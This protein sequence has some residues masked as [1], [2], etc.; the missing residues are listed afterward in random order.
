MK[1]LV[2]GGGGREHALAWKLA[3]SPQAEK[4]YVA[5]GNAGTALAL[6]L[7][8][9]NIAA[10]DTEGLL[11][12]A[13]AAAIDLTVVGPE[14]PLAAGIVDDFQK[15]NLAIFGPNKAC[16]QLEASKAFSKAFM[17]AHRIPTASYR[18]FTD[19]NQ[20]IAYI[21]Q[22]GTPLVIKVDGLAAGK[23]VV[24]AQTETQ[25]IDAIRNILVANKFGKAGTS[26]IIEE[27]LEGEELSF[28]AMVDG[29]TILPLATSQD[30]KARD[31]GNKGP[32]T[33]GMG[34][35]SPASMVTPEI[36]TVIMQQVMRPVVDGMAKAGTPY[37]GFLYA[38][39]ML[40]QEGPK[41]LEFNCRLGDPEAQPIMMRLQGD[42][43][44]LCRLGS[45][46][47]L[48]KGTIKWDPRPAVGVVMA[49]RHYPKTYAKGD[50]IKGLEHSLDHTKVFHAGTALKSSKVVT[51]SGRV[52]CVTA[53][54]DTL[55]QAQERA[56]HLTQ[57]IHW[58]HEF[59]RTDIGHKRSVETVVK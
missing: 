59:Y 51:D 37:V 56:Y 35:Y 52:L 36:E 40:T 49:S 5:P 46:G 21:Q 45:H 28:I 2:I 47:Q 18:T 22:Q 34:A 57:K 14:A 4:V 27:C 3:R 55:A 19:A 33:G 10:N 8:N 23:G 1:L 58:G 12:F 42:F 48:A 50:V 44:E 6:N 53:L 41:V 30:H 9:I 31:D 25:A 17:Q 16:A 54:G 24:V 39:L 15:K 20:A 38:G 32:N 43:T 7:E 11:E 26:V 29:K 13:Q